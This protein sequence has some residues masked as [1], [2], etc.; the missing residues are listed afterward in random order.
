M[1]ST[2]STIRVVLIAN[3][4]EIALRVIR[5]CRAAGL[6]SV[7]IHTDLDATAPHVREADD[8]VR[9]ESYLD[10]D[11]VV[12]AAQ[13]A[14]ADAIHPGYGFLSERAAFAR[15]VERG[16]HQ[17]R[18]P[19]GRGDGEDGPQGRRPRDRRRRRCSR[20]PPRRGLDPSTGSGRR[21]LDHPTRRIPGAGEGR[22]RRWRQGH[23]DRPGAEGL[24]RRGGLRQAGGA[25]GVRRRHH[26]RREVRRARPSHRGAGA[27]RLP[28]QRRPPLRA[29]LL[30]PAPA[31]EGDRGGA[32]SDDH[33]GDPHAGHRVGR[34]AGSRGRLR[35]RRHGGVPARPGGERRHRRG[36]LPRDE[37][38]APG[39]APRH[40]AGGP[41]PGTG[42]GPGAAPAG[43]RGRGAAAV[44]PGRGDAG[45]ATRSRRAST[46]R[47][48]GT[49][50]SRRRAPRRS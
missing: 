23:A 35:E 13:R 5:A 18:G 6:H 44:H 1:A 10:V 15:A 26:P 37:H 9:V 11:A 3:R 32:G 36:V 7:A 4:G 45:T 38:P 22:G 47:T 20:R 2:S 34:G 48:R 25:G 40:R 41:G 19:V 17:A 49:T 16:G 33:P 46:P 21:K 30:H 31:P 24:R 39:R 43:R 12:A 29:R 42:A 8:A 14:G 27:R 28:R 50:S